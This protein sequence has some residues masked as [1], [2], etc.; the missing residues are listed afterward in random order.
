MTPMNN[1]SQAPQTLATRQAADGYLDSWNSQ[2]MDWDAWMEEVELA[3][4]GFAR[5]INAPVEHV[6][7]CPSV[8]TAVSS[9]VSA[10][11]YDD[12]RVIVSSEAEFP[13]V[14]HVLLAQEPRGAQ[15]RWAPLEDG[16]VAS[17]GYRSLVDDD[18]LL[19]SVTHAYYENGSKQDLAPIIDM[20]HERGAM[21]LVDAYQTLGTE[22]VDVT[23]LDVDFL[24]GGCL[25]YLMGI[26]GIAFLYIKGELIERLEP[27]VTGWFGRRDPFA[28]E[29]KRLDW[30]ATAAR[31]DTGTPAIVSAAVAR[32]G[33]EIVNTVGP[34]A[35]QKWT[36]QLSR[37]LIDG[38]RQR[39][40]E[41]CSPADPYAK[42]PTT[43][44]RMPVDAQDVET[45][46]RSRGVLPSARGKVI[47]LAPHFYNT[48]EDV[49]TALDTLAEVLD[50][51]AP[52]WSGRR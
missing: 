28:F 42:S 16:A 29:A 32:A 36:E 49:D 46:M 40:L 47:R 26:P 5:L 1:C 18:T 37:R 27:T 20:A 33:L 15:V 25:K 50:Q 39:G 14:G 44:F 19:L 23:A 48:L 34:S 12:R 43:A 2:G 30:S 6:A 24:T 22:P 11:T 45:A 13:T 9:L 38:G 3:R 31:F 35:I 7:V 4:G 21:V 10:L 8:S 41:L 52:S 51:L 17:A